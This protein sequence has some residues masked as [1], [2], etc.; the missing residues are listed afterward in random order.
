MDLAD[1]VDRIWD[2][3]ISIEEF[4]TGSAAEEGHVSRLH[5]EGWSEVA[6]GIAFWPARSNVSGIRTDT[7]L[8]LV[9]TGEGRTVT[10][11][12]GGLRRWSA[13]PVRTV[14][15]THGHPD[16]IGGLVALDDEATTAGLPRPHVIA[17]E[18]V[19]DRFA[20][21]ERSFEYNAIVNRRQFQDSTIAWPSQFRY[22]DQTYCGAVQVEVGG[23]VVEL[24]HGRGETDDATW[25]WLPERRVICCGDF[26]MWVAPNAGNPQK[27]QRYAGD[28]AQALRAMIPLDAELL[29]PGHGLPIFGADRVRTALADTASFLESLHDQTLELMNRGATLD[30]IIHSVRPPA[31]LLERPYLRPVFDDPEFVVRNV[32]RFY[33][34][35]YGGNPATLKPAPDAELASEVSE[36][37]GGASRLAERAQELVDAGQWRLATHL[38]HMAALAS[39]DDRKVLET[40]RTVFTGR[41]ARERSSMARSIFGWAAAQAQHAAADL[42]ADPLHPGSAT[43]RAGPD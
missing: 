35:W 16:H 14:I 17:H 8:L 23:V 7:G 24:R 32:W 36:L 20:K 39:P 1:Y 33:G 12:L 25:V 18:A 6:P 10:E 37:A 43:R 31:D 28:W 21:Y 15:L 29:L 42:P 34:G 41:A 5:A 4:H 13:D 19:P 30:E 40:S 27:S 3:R 9:D 22:P 11:M 26:F 2:G 38:A